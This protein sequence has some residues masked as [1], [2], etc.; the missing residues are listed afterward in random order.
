M[1]QHAIRY[2]IRPDSTDPHHTTSHAALTDLLKD[3]HH[4]TDPH[5][6]DPQTETASWTDT[7]SL[8]TTEAD[9]ISTS[10]SPSGHA[11][12]GTVAGPV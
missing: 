3:H 12:T 5:T 4:P 8:L 2:G 10:S 6:P 9:K 7:L 1:H 11:P